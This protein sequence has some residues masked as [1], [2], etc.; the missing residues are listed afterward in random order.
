MITSKSN[1]KI[2]QR[3]TNAHRRKISP[4]NTTYNKLHNEEKHTKNKLHDGERAIKLQ[5]QEQKMIKQN[6]TSP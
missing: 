1:S 2:S 5:I 3:N 4:Q 6:N